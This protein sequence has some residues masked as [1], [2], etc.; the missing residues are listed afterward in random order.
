MQLAEQYNP[1]YP[2]FTPPEHY[3]LGFTRSVNIYLHHS[4]VYATYIYPIYLISMLYT[5]YYSITK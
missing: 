4:N 1:T 5:I 2:A 3:P